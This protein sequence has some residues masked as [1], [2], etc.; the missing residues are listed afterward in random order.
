ME[1][2]KS[3]VSV[4]T[5]A[6]CTH[7]TYLYFSSLKSLKFSQH[8]L[9]PSILLFPSSFSQFTQNIVFLSLNWH[10]FCFSFTVQ[11][12]PIHLINYYLICPIILHYISE[13]WER[14][15]VYCIYI[16]LNVFHW[17]WTSVLWVFGGDSIGGKMK[18]IWSNWIQCITCVLRV[19]MVFGFRQ[20]FPFFMLLLLYYDYCST[21]QMKGGWLKRSKDEANKKTKLKVERKLFSK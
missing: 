20:W 14:K 6:A 13:N 12:T 1:N 18:P 15:G 4:L 19:K 10:V 11:I 21:H 9:S 17:C 5:P 8:I 2:T 7:C 3:N 16:S